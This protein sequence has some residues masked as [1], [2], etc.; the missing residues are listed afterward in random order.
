MYKKFQEK[1]KSSANTHV[2]CLKLKGHLSGSCQNSH[3]AEYTARGWRNWARTMSGEEDLSWR[4]PKFNDRKNNWR[5]S[6]GKAMKVEKLV[7]FYTFSKK[8][9]GSFLTDLSLEKSHSCHP[10]VTA[11]G[12]EN[13]LL[14]KKLDVVDD[15]CWKWYFK[16]F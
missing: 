11:I 6:W 10:F 9:H 12:F 16:N 5:R 13:T 7:D 8:A 4:A 2:R 3:K 14:E 15:C 1:L